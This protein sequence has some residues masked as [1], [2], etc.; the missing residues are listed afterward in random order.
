MRLANPAALQLLLLVPALLLLLRW[1]YRRNARFLA[2]LREGG[3]ARTTYTVYAALLTVMLVCLI[4][5]AAQPQLTLRA[6]GGQA[7]RGD[8]V[9]LVDVSRSMMARSSSSQP[10]NLELAR[11]II[12]RVIQD[13]PEGR[14][15]IAAYAA[16]PFSLSSFSN[17]AAYLD[18]VVKNGLFVG[19]I[20]RAGSNLPGALALAARHKHEDPLWAKVTQVVLL[21]DGNITRA[22]EDLFGK[23]VELVNAAGLAIDAVGIGDPRGQR[24]NVVDASGNVTEKYETLPD[25]TQVVTALREDT[26]RRAAERTGGR[27]FPQGDV[28]DLIE[29]LRSTLAPREEQ[30]AAEASIVVGSRDMSWVLLVPFTLA[31]GILLW[32]RRIMW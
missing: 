17:D 28:A 1:A 4:G 23:A 29:Y 30:T 6:S 31:L 19:V 13:V 18:D 5:I 21:A 10:T 24:I 3:D 27:Y 7:P 20:P 2:L 16:L 9:F 26:L 14:F 8:Y 15:A 12:G 25:G 11:G 32:D 22:Q